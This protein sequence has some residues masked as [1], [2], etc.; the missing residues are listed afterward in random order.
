MA[1][2]LKDDDDDDDDD[3]V[4]LRSFNIKRYVIRRSFV[5]SQYSGRDSLK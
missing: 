3:D 1:Y 5:M 4:L 2:N